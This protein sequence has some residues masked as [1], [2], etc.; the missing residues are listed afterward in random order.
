MISRSIFFKP[1]FARPLWFFETLHYFWKRCPAKW[2]P[3]I[4]P[5]QF[6]YL[7][8]FHQSNE[9]QLKDKILDRVKYKFRRL[10]LYR[11]V[12]YDFDIE[13]KIFQFEIL[14]IFNN[15][16]FS[17]ENILLFRLFNVNHLVIPENPYLIGSFSRVSQK[18]FQVVGF[19]C[20][21]TAQIKLAE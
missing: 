2:D 13:K 8:H 18:L 16:Q 15:Y 5:W 1:V 3:D 7:V 12:F 21:L 17:N 19:F 11:K 6:F 14:S 9:R 4:L 10:C 20:F